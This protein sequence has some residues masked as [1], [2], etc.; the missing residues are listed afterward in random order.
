MNLEWPTPLAMRIGIHSGSVVA[1]IIGTHKFVYDIWDDSLNITSRMESH[2]LPNR[3]QV[4]AATHEHLRG[5]F[6]LEPHGSVDVKGKGPMDT[7]FLLGR[8]AVRSL[9]HRR[10]GD[11]RHLAQRRHLGECGG[12]GAQLRHRHVTDGLE[13]PALVVDQRHCGVLYPP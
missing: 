3:S 7:Y 13:K 2:G 12:M 6:R 1:G 4:S 5:Q 8:G 11:H 10:G 9:R